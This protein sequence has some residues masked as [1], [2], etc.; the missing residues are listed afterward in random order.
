MK[1][2][3]FIVISIGFCFLGWC[4]QDKGSI[5]VSKE[6]K[7]VFSVP[8]ACI[9]NQCFQVEIAATEE[10]R[11][12]W[13]MTRTSL[14]EHS[15][16]IFIFNNEGIYRFWM[17]NTIIPLDMIR[18][19]SWYEIKDIQEAVPCKSDPC[20]VYT[21]VTKASYVLEINKWLS[22]KYKIT[23]G[24]KVDIYLNYPNN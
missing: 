12:F 11:T 21:P 22:K 4:S 2:A 19:N 15:G 14:G 9:K 10:E 6:I 18:I 8:T 16:M 13:L 5:P 23:T 1:K 3:L 17:K 7:K 24:E 20:I